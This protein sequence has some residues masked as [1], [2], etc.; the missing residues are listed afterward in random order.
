[1]SFCPMRMKPLK[2]HLFL[3]HLRLI[4][5]KSSKSSL[6]LLLSSLLL[7][8][9][10]SSSTVLQFHKPGTCP[11]PQ[12]PLLLL[13]SGKAWPQANPPVSP[14]ILLLTPTLL[15]AVVCSPQ[16]SASLSTCSSQPTEIQATSLLQKGKGRKKAAF[17]L[18][19]CLLTHC[20]LLP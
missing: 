15:S 18:I 5:S 7:S 17:C 4:N 19:L 16:L 1:M 11:S 3:M 14:T 13:G 12:Q 20:L 9:N 8:Y 6:T 2:A 10:S